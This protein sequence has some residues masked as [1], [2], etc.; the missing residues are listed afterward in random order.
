[1]I[2][3]KKEFDKIID[4][5]ITRCKTLLKEKFKEYQSGDDMLSNFNNVAHILRTCPEQAW[6]GMWV[7]HVESIVTMIKGR[8]ELCPSKRWDEKIT[9]C[10]NY[11][12]LLQCLLRQQKNFKEVPFERYK[13]G[14]TA[15]DLPSYRCVNCQ[16]EITHGDLCEECDKKLY[17]KL[18]KKAL[19][20]IVDDEDEEQLKEVNNV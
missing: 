14:W 7:K 10:I 16:K 15:K 1:M 5:Q 12:L 13:E 4:D 6:L 18:K 2:T 8:E 17:K 19:S 9:D 11:L 20:G 3:D